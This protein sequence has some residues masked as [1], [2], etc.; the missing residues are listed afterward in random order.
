[1]QWVTASPSTVPEI[2]RLWPLEPEIADYHKAK[3]L[4]GWIEGHSKEF[5]ALPWPL[6]P[7]GLKPINYP[8]DVLD[9]TSPI[10]EGPA[11]HLIELKS[12]DSTRSGT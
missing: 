10:N 9:K 7:L 1:M 3:I 5:E 6:N 4:Q 12:Y 11:L 8:W 2:S